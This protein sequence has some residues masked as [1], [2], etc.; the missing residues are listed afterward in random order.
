MKEYLIRAGLIWNGINDEPF[1][2]GAVRI[3]DGRIAE[4]M[5]ADEIPVRSV[6]AEL[7]FPGYT[8]MPGLIDAHT[9]LSMDGE[10]EHYLDHMR[11]PVAELTLRAVAMMKRDIKGGITTCRCCGDR[12]FLDIA[13]RH[14][15]KDGIVR[16]PNLLVATRGIRHP[17]GHGFVGYPFHGPEGIRWAIAE[18]AEAGADFIKIYI[19]GTLRDKGD[20]PS[21]FSSSEIEAAIQEAHRSGLRITA[22]CVGGEGLDLA[23]DLGLDCVEHIYHISDDQIMKINRSAIFVVLTPGPILSEDRIM[24]LPANL[25]PGHLK[26]KEMIRKRMETFIASGKPFAIGTDGLHGRLGQE[27]GYLVQMGASTLQVLRAATLGGAIVSGIEDR[28]GSLEPGKD[29]DMILVDGNPFTDI[30][31][32]K[33]ICGVWKRGEQM[34]RENGNFDS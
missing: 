15:V 8:L 32:L 23:I 4:V 33:R 5:A 26:E 6:I 10:L 13:C 7:N 34:D 14:A 9:H 21:Y 29:A 12:E 18:N 2:N 31:V 28:T 22:H 20:L 17:E 25:I 3:Q 1:Q 16:G 24:R 30:S 11:D 19:S 27:M